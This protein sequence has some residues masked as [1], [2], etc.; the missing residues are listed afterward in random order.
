M[1]VYQASVLAFVCG[2]MLVVYVSGFIYM[3]KVF[4]WV[5]RNA[6]ATTPL[7]QLRAAAFCSFYV[8]FWPYTLY[9]IYGRIDRDERR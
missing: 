9:V 4:A 1:N 2:F 6:N 7:M 8:I 3:A 5:S